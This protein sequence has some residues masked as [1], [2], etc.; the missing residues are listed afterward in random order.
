MLVG[1]R[2]YSLHQSM[3]AATPQLEWHDLAVEVNQRALIDKILAR[4]SGE[5]TVYRGK[6][7]QFRTFRK[8]KAEFGVTELLQ[9]AEDANA[10]SVEIRFTSTALKSS[11]KL[12]LATQLTKSITVRN[13]G[14][15]FSE[16][17]WTRL[18]KI[19]EGNPD[20]SKVGAFVSADS[21]SSRIVLTCAGRWLLFLVLAVRGTDRQL[22]LRCCSIL[23]ERRWRPACKSSLIYMLHPLTVGKVCQKSCQPESESLD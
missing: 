21:W 2:P 7:H 22:G 17:D 10:T 9:N 8:R 19:A 5:N 3:S 23:L 12:D 15:V 20:E 4:Y 1:R 6:W 14:D 11:D 13:N 18:R 16:T